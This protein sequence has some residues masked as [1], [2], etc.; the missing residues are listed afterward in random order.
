MM[1]FSPNLRPLFSLF[2]FVFVSLCADLPKRSQTRRAD[3]IWELR[4]RANELHQLALLHRQEAA[5]LFEIAELNA[6]HGHENHVMGDLEAV[7]DDLAM[8]EKYE[9][10]AAGLEARAEELL[11]P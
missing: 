2:T 6:Q 11:S 4:S 10:E 5:E 9:L 3:E 7:R 8:A 1:S